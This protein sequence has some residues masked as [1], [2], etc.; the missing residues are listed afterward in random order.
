MSSDPVEPKADTRQRLIEAASEI[1]IEQGYKAAKIRDIVQRAGANVAAIN[2]HFNGK[3][4]LYAEVIRQHAA[5]A[6][7]DFALAAAEEPRAPEMQLRNYIRTFLKR[8]L[9]NNVQ[10]RMA[11]LIARESVE[12]SA[13]FNLV[14][15]QFVIPQH[16]ALHSTV[17]AI[18]GE[19]VAEEHV[20]RCSMSIIGQCL[21]YWSARRVVTCLDPDLHYSA[22]QV[23]RLADHIVE[24]SLAGMNQI[25]SKQIPTRGRTRSAT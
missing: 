22:E 5:Q 8:L 23:D 10:S 13:A 20:R 18:L 7:E 1:F 16:V 19:A 21:Y 17:R 14:V 9:G 25:V 2:Y 3:E 15:E 4:G 6:I 24:F 12:P 11:R